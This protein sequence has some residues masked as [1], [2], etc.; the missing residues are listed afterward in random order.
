MQADGLVR[1]QPGHLEV[2]HPLQSSERVEQRAGLVH[3][4]LAERGRDR[5]V[6]VD[7]S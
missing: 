6:Q 5:E 3:H 4:L 1:V 2:G 7:R